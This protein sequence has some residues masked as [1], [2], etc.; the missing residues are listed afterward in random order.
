MYTYRYMLRHRT[1]VVLL[2]LL[3][4]LILSSLHSQTII[5]SYT[6]IITYSNYIIFK[7]CRNSL[8]LCSHSYSILTQNNCL[9]HC[10]HGEI[11]CAMSTYTD[12][13]FKKIRKKMEQIK[14][15]SKVN[16][17]NVQHDFCACHGYSKA[18]Y[19]STVQVHSI[20]FGLTS[21]LHI[22]GYSDWNKDRSATA[23]RSILSWS[24]PHAECLGIQ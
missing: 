3:S 1:H 12:L 2:T 17:Q 11:A 22:L 7:W 9:F 23:A 6:V 14:S 16:F 10:S 8:N 5:Y 18:F 21:I 15:I 24:L 19:N 13:K 20:S 4:S